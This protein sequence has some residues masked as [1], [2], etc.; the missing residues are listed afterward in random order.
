MK[1]H[2]NLVFGLTLISLIQISCHPKKNNTE[3]SET[4]DSINKSKPALTIKDTVTGFNISLAPG[5]HMFK[6]PKGNYILFDVSNEADSLTSKTPEEQ[7]ESKTKTNSECEGPDFDGSYRKVVKYTPSKKPLEIINDAG[8]LFTQLATTQTEMCNNRNSL[9][10][11][12]RTTQENRNV[13]LKTVYLYTFKRQSDE[14]YHVIFGTTNNINNAKFF[15][16]EISGLSPIGTYGY[17]KLKKVRTD[18]ETYFQVNNTCRN[19]YYKNDF[20]KHPIKICLSGS[21]FYDGEH[22]THYQDNGP[23]NWKIMEVKVAWEIHPITSL[24]FLE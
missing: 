12:S 10:V 18:F 6:T 23:Q 16:A 7:A 8:E 17:D 19:S 1:I 11:A 22:C 9:P 24:E 5:T 15:N 21:L 14:D 20:R 13:Q 4:N 3:T 2:I